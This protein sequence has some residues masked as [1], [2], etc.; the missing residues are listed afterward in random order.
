LTT[1][2]INT[3][4]NLTPW[5]KSTWTKTHEKCKLLA[6][7]CSQKVFKMSTICADTCLEVLSPRSIA[8]SMMSYRK[9]HRKCSLLV[10][11]LDILCLTVSKYPNMGFVGNLVLFASVKVFCKLIKNWPSY[12]HVYIGWHP[13]WLTVYIYSIHLMR[14]S[15]WPSRSWKNISNIQFST[16]FAV[17]TWMSC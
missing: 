11:T 16:A 13:F 9:S 12:S 1:N 3:V 7:V 15:Q 10:Q 14:S 2:H 6:R 5:T 8:V 17:L 4:K